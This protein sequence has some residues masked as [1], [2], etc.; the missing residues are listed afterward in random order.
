MPKVFVLIEAELPTHMDAEDFAIYAKDSVQACVGGYHPND[1][2]FALDRKSVEAYVVKEEKS[3]A[4]KTLKTF[5]RAHNNVSLVK[6][7]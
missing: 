4:I 3:H 5:I 2:I 1:P 7:L 6:L